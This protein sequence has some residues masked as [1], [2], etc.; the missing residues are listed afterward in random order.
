MTNNQIIFNERMNL[1]EAGIIRSTGRK[2]RCA[3]TDD[4]G[5]ESVMI[6]DEPEELHTFADWKARGY[7]VQKGQKAIAKFTIWNH[8]DRKRKKAATEEEKRLAALG[9][10]VDVE[11]GYFYMKNACF[12][13][14]HQVAPINAAPAG[15]KLLPALWDGLQ[16][17]AVIAA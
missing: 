2:M 8:A 6:V 4:N 17:P 15:E 1:L 3:Y 13:A 12:F 14:A 11:S 10:S 16:L 7:M 9:E 5:N